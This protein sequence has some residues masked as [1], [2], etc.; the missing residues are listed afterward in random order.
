M[1]LEFTPGD[2]WSQYFQIADDS[3]NPIGDSTWGAEFFIVDE[4]GDTQLAY[5]NV[6]ET[7]IVWTQPGMVVVTFQQTET[8][9]WAWSRGSWA[10]NIISPSTEFDSQGS[11]MT[12][13]AGF[14]QIKSAAP[15][16]SPLAT[17]VPPTPVIPF[18][19]SRG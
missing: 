12:A 13:A 19:S 5:T 6:A 7:G 17:S 9:L 10:L 4:D 8:A 3:G 18:P 2:T 16:F 11:K 14:A 15:C 1:L